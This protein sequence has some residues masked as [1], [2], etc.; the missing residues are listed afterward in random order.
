MTTKARNEK[1]LTIIVLSVF[2]FLSTRQHKV[3]MN[4]QFFV[5]RIC[6]HFSLLAPASLNVFSAVLSLL[7]KKWCSLPPAGCP[8]MNES[9]D[10]AR[11]YSQSW[12]NFLP[13]GV[14]GLNPFSNCVGNVE[15]PLLRLFPIVLLVL[16]LGL[17]SLFNY[18]RQ[19]YAQNRIITAGNRVSTTLSSG[20]RCGMALSGKPTTNGCLRYQSLPLLYMLAIGMPHVVSTRA[21]SH[22]LCITCRANGK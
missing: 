10:F 14:E 12:P 16:E 11:Q 5:Y 19:A 13:G 17:Y 2:E 7:L 20:Q 21:K 1:N 15:A 6:R 9:V 8:K 4:S 3:H 22:L 18:L